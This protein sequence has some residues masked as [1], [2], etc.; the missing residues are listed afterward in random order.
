MKT[1]SLTMEVYILALIAI[2]LLLPLIYLIYLRFFSPPSPTTS[3]TTLKDREALVVKEI[4][5]EDISGKVKPIDGNK[6]WSATADVEIEQG[7]KV[8]I[9]EVKGVHVFVEE[10]K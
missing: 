4:K 6:L 2:V 10:I 9:T 3:S 7:V 8:K 5:P 1:Y